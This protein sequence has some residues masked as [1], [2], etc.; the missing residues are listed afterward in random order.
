M[1]PSR[2]HHQ[3]N[4]EDL[5]SRA[6]ELPPPP[7]APSRALTV[8]GLLLPLLSALSLSLLN[9]I[10]SFRP[11]GS[12]SDCPESFTPRHGSSCE[13]ENAARLRIS[14]HHV[15]GLREGERVRIRPKGSAFSPSPVPPLLLPRWDSFL[16]ESFGICSGLTGTWV[17]P[18]LISFYVL[19]S[20][21]YGYVRKVRPF[22]PSPVPPLSLPRWDSFLLLRGSFIWYPF[23]G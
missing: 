21:E 23:L 5:C 18:C 20:C 9:L 17:D 11:S 14:S 22:L 16:L 1:P 10:S 4:D 12:P 7:L 15:R 8:T 3:H 13:A 2:H 19:R 6:S